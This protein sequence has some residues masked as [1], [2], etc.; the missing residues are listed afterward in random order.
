[1]YNIYIIRIDIYILYVITYIVIKSYPKRIL[2]ELISMLEV[3]CP[4]VKKKSRGHCISKIVKWCGASRPL[5]GGMHCGIAP[6]FK[7]VSAAFHL[8]LQ[9]CDSSGFSSQHLTTGFFEGYIHWKCL[10]CSLWPVRATTI[11]L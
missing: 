2:S 8:D 6:P 7:S 4:G 11:E 10:E 9:W 1:M 3:H 5:C